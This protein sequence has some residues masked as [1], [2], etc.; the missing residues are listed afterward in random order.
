MR[1][2]KFVFNSA[3]T[4]VVMDTCNYRLFAGLTSGN[5]VQVNLFEKVSFGKTL[6]VHFEKK[7]PNRFFHWSFLDSFRQ[8]IY[9]SS[10]HY[11]K[12]ACLYFFT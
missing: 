3:V 6:C 8:K 2:C 9:I 5:I 10:V 12:L 11:D 7:S 4:S 1:L